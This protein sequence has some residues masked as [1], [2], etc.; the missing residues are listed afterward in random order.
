[1]EGKWGISFEDLVYLIISA[2]LVCLIITWMLSVL[3]VSKKSYDY[4][5]LT[6]PSNSLISE[7]LPQK[8][9]ES[10]STPVASQQLT[11][12][13][14]IHPLKVMRFQTKAKI[15]PPSS[16]GGCN[17]GDC[18]ETVSRIGLISDFQVKSSFP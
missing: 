10:H 14:N 5:L 15:P 11:H 8:E 3:L 16:Q 7:S 12:T 6:P 1:M 4:K 17:K 9:I 13:L 2:G 18:L